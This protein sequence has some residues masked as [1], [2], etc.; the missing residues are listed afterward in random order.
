MFYEIMPNIILPPKKE[1]GY[2][3]HCEQTQYL[4]YT[5]YLTFYRKYFIP[6]PGEKI[7]VGKLSS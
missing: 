3:G 7:L 4:W 2:A 1:N 6:V 5:L